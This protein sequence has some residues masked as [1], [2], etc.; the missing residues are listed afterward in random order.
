M[1]SRPKRQERR[2]AE[3]IQA[4]QRAI[5]KHGADGAI[6]NRIAEEAGVSPGTV[7][8]YYPEIGTLTVETI[9]AAMDRFYTARAGVLDEVGLTTAGRLVRMISLGLPEGPWDEGVRLLCELGGSAARFPVNASLLS[10][11]Y[12]REVGLYQILLERGANEGVFSL[13]LPALEVARNLVSLEDAYGYR[14]IS[15]H[16]GITVAVARQLILDVAR[17]A[18]GNHLVEA[19]ES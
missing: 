13:R 14:I 18:T 6:L 4:T 3:L 5:V 1:V 9:R 2:R 12:D 10:T 16:P 17:I 19:A 15:N 8:Y 7:L 11:L